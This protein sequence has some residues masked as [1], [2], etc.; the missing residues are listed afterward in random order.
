MRD[1]SVQ[2][3]TTPRHGGDGGGV[4]HIFRG[5][6][7]HSYSG[8]A[9]GLYNCSF[10]T[11]TYNSVTGHSY[12]TT[13]GTPNGIGNSPVNGM[14]G[15]NGNDAREQF[16]RPS[17][18]CLF[19]G[20]T[21]PA[22]QT[23]PFC[24]QHLTR[25]SS[26]AQN[27]TDST[28]A[29]T[30]ST[31][32]TTS[33]PP[34]QPRR[35]VGG[36]S[37]QGQASSPTTASLG[38]SRNSTLASEPAVAYLRRKTAQSSGPRPPS[39]SRTPSSIS[40]STP[41]IGGRSIFTNGAP[42]TPSPRIGGDRSGGS[43][44]VSSHTAPRQK[45]VETQPNG[46]GNLKNGST[47][48]GAESILTP[49]ESPPNLWTA[50]DPR[51]RPRT[52]YMDNTQQANGVHITPAG[53]MHGA[54]AGCQNSQAQAT[55][56][57]PSESPGRGPLSTT[58]SSN[59]HE[60]GADVPMPDIVEG[61]VSSHTDPPATQPP[62]QKP[63]IQ[64]PPQQD[65]V[66][67]STA[68]GSNSAEPASGPSSSSRLG[69]R[70]S[71]L[72][73][74]EDRKREK[75]A[76]GDGAHP[77]PIAPMTFSLDTYIYNQG[78][79][80][81]PL[82]PPPNVVIA[83]KDKLEAVSA[84]VSAMLPS[85]YPSRPSTSSGKPEFVYAHIDPRVHWTRIRPKDW[86]EAK[87]KE[88]AARGGRKANFGKAAQRA[89]VARRQDAALVADSLTKSIVESTEANE[90]GSSTRSAKQTRAASKPV[91]PLPPRQWPSVWKGEMPSDVI[92]NKE[93]V[94]MLSKF[95]QDE[96]ARKTKRVTKSGSR[97]KSRQ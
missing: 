68:S 41:N 49:A 78:S 51:K 17:E 80:V 29:T 70:L 93:W 59:A 22:C 24:T 79:E 21:T 25:I 85:T 9:N 64:N 44:F 60:A 87:Q 91:D 90:G 14:A 37:P 34:P 92:H 30:A 76:N 12:I 39:L 4:N 8:N 38:E 86:H 36:P 19:P 31:K 42:A 63:P 75:A 18:P 32:P 96:D 15:V 58:Q 2:D 35:P 48:N 3:T 26:K 33:Q 40:S 54:S 72:R 10:S 43:Y 88:I 62:I 69:L 23:A 20:C 7:N 67:E 82:P 55:T 28:T 50:H 73:R 5:A 65:R 45:M 1:A 84:A 46:S 52:D 74:I 16:T 6:L 47:T 53:S 97:S 56:S 94:S 61:N 77:S 57:K 27:G 13:H 95:A 83:P 71:L 66:A 81:A 11:G 89:A